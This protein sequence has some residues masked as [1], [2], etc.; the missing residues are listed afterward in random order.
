MNIIKRYWRIIFPIFFMALIWY[1]SARNG[2]MSDV[3]SSKY[4]NA[5]GF[6]NEFTRKLAHFVL[7]GAL[8]YS[9]S[10]FIKGL[11]PLTFPKHTHVFYPIILA[12]IWGA[13]DEVHQLTVAGRNGSATDVIIDAFAG[14]AGVLAYVSIFCFYR[15]WKAKKATLNAAITDQLTQAELEI[16]ENRIQD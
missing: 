6:S 8:G 13:L 14:L 12:V 11:H 10:S 15:I 16:E 5:L 7:Y 4:A 2:E 9:A 1:F 3:D